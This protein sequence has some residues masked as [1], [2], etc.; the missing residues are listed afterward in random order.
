MFKK[1]IDWVAWAQYINGNGTY[2]DANEYWANWNSGT[3][4]IDYRSW[5]HHN[6]LG[7]YSFALFE[8]IGGL[9]PRLDNQIELWPIDI[10]YSYFAFNNLRYH[11]SDLT[12]I[13]DSAGSHY[14][15]PA[16]YSVYVN[17][18]RMFTVSR[19]VHLIW[20]SAT[21]SITYPDGS[22]GATAIYNVSNPSFPN[23]NQVTLSGRITTYLQKAGVSITASTPTPTSRPT[24]TPT[25]R[26]S[27]THTPTPTRR[28]NT[29]TFRQ[30][31]TPTSRPSSTQAP[32][33]S[34]TVTAKP[35]PTPTPRPGGNYV[36]HY[37]IT[38]DWGSGANVDVII[39]N[40]TTA[41][42]N[43]WT[44]AW[45]FPGNQTINNMWNAAYTQSGAALSAHNLGYNATIAANGGQVFFGFGLNY[46]GTNAEPTSFTLNGAPCMV[47]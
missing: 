19:L 31:P 38:S 20:N 40:N 32:T 26:P 14:G 7:S 10:G 41:A 33:P 17:G 21:G 43:G 29:P 18:T 34:P 35:T 3:K 27:S 24:P 6:V 4:H 30:T 44:L 13:W 25:S 15:V 8:G 46:S 5:I 22:L 28:V 45:T 1:L 11:G 36:V 2:P 12:I 16:G 37:T 39:T 42:V 9:V 23:A 47:Q